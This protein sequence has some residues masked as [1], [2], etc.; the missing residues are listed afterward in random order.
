MREKKVYSVR[1]FN[2]YQDEPDLFATSRSE[3][4][5]L[6]HGFECS[7]HSLLE[8][9]NGF[10]GLILGELFVSTGSFA[11]VIFDCRGLVCIQELPLLEAL[12]SEITLG[13]IDVSATVSVDHVENCFGFS[14][15]NFLRSR[16]LGAFLLG[17]LGSFG[18]FFFFTIL[19]KAV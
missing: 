6:G 15:V 14:S 3:T 13:F 10:L 11:E 19:S 8:G 16:L 18:S 2:K 9:L 5:L 1:C 17:L 12:K 7:E 4:G